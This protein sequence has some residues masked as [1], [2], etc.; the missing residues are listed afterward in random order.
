MKKISKKFS[1]A[2]KLSTLMTLSLFGASN[3]AKADDLQRLAVS[4]CKSAKTDKRA[5]MRKKLRTARMRLKDLYDGLRC[6]SQGSL[7]RVATNS[8]SLDA[9]KFITTKVG[10]K[11]LTFVEPDG[12]NIIQWTENLVAAGDPSK[13]VFVDLYRSKM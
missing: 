7:L 8:N 11:G 4:L 9:A 12:L 10:K 13:Q 5:V 1:V 3:I 2:I 6:G